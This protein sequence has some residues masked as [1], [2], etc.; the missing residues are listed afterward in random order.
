MSKKR[1]HHE[2]SKKAHQDSNSQKEEVEKEANSNSKMFASPMAELRKNFWKVL[3][4]ILAVVLVVMFFGGDFPGYFASG[5]DIDAI[6][7]QTVTYI[8]T[9]LMPEGQGVF[10][11]DAE[12]KN[13]LG[14]ITILAG[15][16]PVQ[17][18]ATLDGELL[19]IPQAVF[20][21]S[22]PLVPS[23]VPEAPTSETPQVD[24]FVMS[25]CPYGNIAEDEQLIKTGDNVGKPI[26]GGY[27]LGSEI[28]KIN[29][30]VSY[31]YKR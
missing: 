19:I 16:S 21:L 8:N 14:I 20:N 30:N 18:M 26:K 7:E 23:T 10:L 31:E 17:I 22:E 6:S 15:D 9:N 12:I 3:T 1:K 2:S 4:I 28:V 29:L 24:L 13:G 25:F 11:L 5:T 27:S